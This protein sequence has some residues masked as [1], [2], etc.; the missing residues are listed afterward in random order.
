MHDEVL[1]PGAR[2]LL[3]ELG[4]QPWSGEFYLAGGTALALQLGHRISV[5]FD[6]FSPGCG[7][8]EPERRAI[9]ESLQELDAGL[10]VDT[11]EDQTLKVLLDGIAVS[12]FHYPNALIVPS[13]LSIGDLA[14]A[15]LDDI[16]LM[17]LAAIIG[18]GHRRDFIDLYFILKTRSL[19]D[20]LEKGACKFPA[21][22][23]FTLQASRALAYFADADR[24]RPPRMLADVE[25][26]VVREFFTAE[27]ERSG[28]KWFGLGGRGG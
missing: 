4:R 28:G 2:E 22:R 21:A 11:E 25:W 6:L 7:L 18:R 24:D 13:S 17:K 5:D 8:T 10:K 20:L 16:G 15:S 12:F 27:V 9:I 1:L 3:T 19:E 23:D 26:S 14:L